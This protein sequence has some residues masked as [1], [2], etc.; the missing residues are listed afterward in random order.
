MSAAGEENFDYGKYA[1]LCQLEVE[2]G[3]L[4]A[5]LLQYIPNSTNGL[6]LRLDYG[7]LLNLIFW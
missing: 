2:T 7:K 1:R 4:V 3:V 6:R 5:G